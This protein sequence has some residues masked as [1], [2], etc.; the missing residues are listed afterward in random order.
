MPRCP[1]SPTGASTPSMAACSTSCSVPPTTS[2]G[3]PPAPSRAPRSPRISCSAARTPSSSTP[4]WSPS[5]RTTRVNVHLLEPRRPTCPTRS[6]RADSS[7][8]VPRGPIITQPAQ[9]WRRGEY[10]PTIR[11]YESEGIPIAEMVTAGSFEGGDFM[12]VEPGVAAIG[13]GEERTQEQAARQVARVARRRRLGGPGRAHPAPLPP[14]RRARLHARREAGGGRASSRPSNGFVQWL[15]S[16][17]V[18]IVPGTPEAALKLGVN[19]V[20]LGGDRVAV[21][22][23]VQGTRLSACAPSA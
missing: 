21:D 18:Q 1:P 14:H 19:G 6:S 17:G 5:T 13:T 7:I 20:C 2:T 3:C 12:I 22:G 8:N 11:F 4:R 15:E 16:K 9:Y 10:A 23:R